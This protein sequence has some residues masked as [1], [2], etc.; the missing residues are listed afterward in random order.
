M[1]Q[2]GKHTEKATTQATKVNA[3]TELLAPRA[4]MEVTTAGSIRPMQP[5][6]LLLLIYFPVVNEPINHQSASVYRSCSQ[7]LWLTE[8]YYSKVAA[9]LKLEDKG[10]CWFV[11][12]LVQWPRGM[13]TLGTK[14]EAVF[15]DDNLWGKVEKAMA[16]D[17]STLAWKIPWMESLVGCSTWGR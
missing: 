6:E 3:L 10:M 17:S 1:R 16:P 8:G 5:C 12:D 15:L 14:E 7:Q 4:H 9:W 13:W 2:I 11:A